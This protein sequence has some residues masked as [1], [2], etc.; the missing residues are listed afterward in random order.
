M[1]KLISLML[2]VLMVALCAC[3]FAEG[4]DV[5]AKTAFVQ[6]KEGVTAQV[7]KKPGDEKAVDTIPGGQ[8]CGLLDEETSETGAA[9]FQVFYLN[10]KKNG[11]T[12]YINAEDAEQLTEEQL[13][14]LMNDPEKLNEILDLVEALDAYLGKKSGNAGNGNATAENELTTLYKMAMDALQKLFS[15]G[16]SP[17][18]DDLKKQGKE[19]ADKA[20]EAGKDL[21][22]NA[23]KAGKDLKDGV[24]DALSSLD[25]KETGEAIDSLMD[26]INDAIEKRAGKSDQKIEDALD[27]VSDA[28]KD[29][30]T[31]LGTNTGNTIDKFANDKFDNIVNKTK[32]WLN[33][34]DFSK[35]KN[36][37][38]NLAEKFKGDGFVSGTGKNG[39]GS[40]LDDLKNIFST[41]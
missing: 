25:G 22:D 31:K 20:K 9:W 23:K 40:F 16:A 29:L 7:F 24:T 17:A 33:N 27:K 37:M 26:S 8:I 41:K 14:A 4:T 28:L 15:A 2:A 12:G 18:L 38:N 32:D 36:A 5:S 19:L 30:D 39:I 13:K 11:T 1:K 34:T 3:G 35:V 21:I 6:I 10:S